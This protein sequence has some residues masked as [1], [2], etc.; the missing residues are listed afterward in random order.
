MLT[1]GL[2][3]SWCDPSSISSAVLKPKPVPRLNDC[4]APGSVSRSAARDGLKTQRSRRTPVRKVF[5][6]GG[7]EWQ[8]SGETGRSMPED[9]RSTADQLNS[10]D[11][12]RLMY[13]F[14]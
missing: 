3:Q 12:T 7:A 10:L 4:L 8:S 2:R 14:V 11:S 9:M 6:S 1:Y 13:L 5:R